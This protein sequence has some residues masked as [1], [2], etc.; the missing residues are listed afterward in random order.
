MSHPIM[1]SEDDPLL[2]KVRSLA[3][4]FPG[5]QQKVSHGRP[6]FFTTKV[7]CYYGGSRKVDGE[8]EQHDQAIMVKMDDDERAALSQDARFWIPA[9]LGGSGWIGLDLDNATDWSEVAELIDAS[10]RSTAG[11]RL[12]R[13]LDGRQLAEP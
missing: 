1:F 9:Y 2:A 4:A 8:W 12:I 6:A 7:F 13:E 5:A 10:Y 11:V 3:L